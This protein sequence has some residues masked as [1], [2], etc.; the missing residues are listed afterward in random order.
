MLTLAL[1]TS[2]A[3]GSIALLQGDALL[4]GEGLPADRR[5]ASALAPAVAAMLQKLGIQPADIGLVATT[6]GP[7]SFTGLR[8]GVTTAKALAYAIGCDAIGLDT[9]DVIAWQAP[10]TADSGS[11]LHALLDAQ[12]KELFLA[13]YRCIEGGPV[14]VGENQIISAE[15]WLASLAPGTIVTGPGLSK[16]E[17][18]LP[19]D[20]T[21]VEPA[22][23]PPQAETVARLALAAHARGR[24]DDVWKLAPAY[25]RASAAEEK[26]SQ[27]PSS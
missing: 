27:A 23:R 20:V 8:V 17:Q 1:E 14:R 5:S 9:L 26:A 10:R 13:R 19:H 25:L 2:A 18:R 15:Q 6:I 7:G 16:I 24:R 22:H 11:E 3:G 21:A 4:A 12:R